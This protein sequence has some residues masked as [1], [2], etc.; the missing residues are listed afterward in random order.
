LEES[1][2]GTTVY[3]VG[4]YVRDGLLGRASK[5]LDL[6]VELPDFES[7]RVRVAGRGYKIHEERSWALTIRAGSKHLGDV[8]FVVC[9]RDG[10]YSNSRRPDEVQVGTLYED[11]SRRD[12]TINAMA[13]GSDGSFHD[14]FGGLKD[15]DAEIIRCV[16]DPD[17]RLIEED[18]LRALRALRFATTLGFRLDYDLLVTLQDETLAEL[19]RTSIPDD[20]IRQELHKMF[21]TDTVSSIQLLRQFPSLMDV[22]FAGDVWLKPTMEKKR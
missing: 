6:A 18:A 16:G 7:L 1:V 21:V 17:Q 12:F 19:V 9:R 11:L 10:V 20:R 4:G 8:D 14:P 22:C 13:V 5:D 2:F 3:A 15:L